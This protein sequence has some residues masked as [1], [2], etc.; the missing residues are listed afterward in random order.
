LRMSL[1]AKPRW[2]TDL[3]DLV[4]YERWM[5]IGHDPTC[6]AEQKGGTF[7]KSIFNYFHK[8][9]HLGDHP[10]EIDQ[11]EA[12]ITKR[13]AFIQEQCTKFNVAYEQKKRKWVGALETCGF[14]LWSNSK[15]PT[16]INHS[17]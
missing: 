14:K 16:R 9:K 7:W 3:E 8:Y 11:S 13:W 15:L 6:G 1:L 2:N 10:F 17:T 5:E 12:S 4:I